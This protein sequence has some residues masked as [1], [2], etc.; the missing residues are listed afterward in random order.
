MDVVLMPT[1]LQ[2]HWHALA[3][4]VIYLQVNH[5]VNSG[6]QLRMK[7]QMVQ[8]HGAECCVSEQEGAAS[9]EIL[10]TEAESTKNNDLRDLLPYGIAIHHAGMP[11]ADRTLVEDLFGDRHIQVK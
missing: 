8:A 1:N 5:I 4:H 7:L 3:T 2:M 10:Q 6:M 11:R 9:R